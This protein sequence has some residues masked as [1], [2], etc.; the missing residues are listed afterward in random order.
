VRLLP[1][2]LRSRLAVL[3]ALGSAALLFVFTFGLY[4]VLDRQL[5]AAVD[6][7]LK[8]RATDLAVVASGSDGLIP[9]RDPFAQTMTL[10]GHVVDQ[11]P[12][13]TEHTPVLTAAQLATVRS[14]RYFEGEVRELGGHAELLAIPIQMRGTRMVLVVGS[15]IDGY[16]RA[17][18]RLE[19]VLIVASPLLVGLLAGAGWVLAGAALRPVRRMTEEADEIAVNELGR[20]LPVPESNDEIEHLARTI[21]A[22]LGRIERAVANERMFIDDA[23]HELRTPISILRGEL[24]LALAR[25]DDEAEVIASLHSALDEA[26]RLGRLAEDLLALA[27][28]RSGELQLRPE[29][30]DLSAATE[31]VAHSLGQSGPPIQ[32]AGSGSAW[33]DPDRIDQILTNLLVNAQRH[34]RAQ[35]EV[36]ARADG[37]TTWLTVADDG[38][39]F[40]D[41]MLPVTFERFV[42]PDPAR[43]RD[44]GG[45]GLGLAIVAALARAQGAT[46]DAGNDSPLGGAMVRIGFPS[47]RSAPAGSAARRGLARRQ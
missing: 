10:D 46:I 20:R 27:R 42:R 5:L 14:G 1:S 6:S 28:V 8:N 4:H 37:A 25:P 30:V 23:S 43:G 40:P 33:A 24:E 11:A 19:L 13:T 3:F 44:T 36:A 39:G 26:I 21:N 22:M 9:D 38:P 12:E 29:S 15:S 47:A 17:R 31:R 18:E 34:A 7:G 35:V 16:D 41:S 2:S 45:T 32:V